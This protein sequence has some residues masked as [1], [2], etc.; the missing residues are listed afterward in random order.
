[1]EEVRDTRA[2]S[3]RPGGGAPRSTDGAILEALARIERRLD[4]VEALA[5]RARTD[6]THALAG[7]V[8]GFDGWMA[9][10]AERGVDV[11]E[12]AR[13]A[14]RLAERATDPRILG[15]LERLLDVVEQAPGGAAMLMDVVDGAVARMQAAGIDVDQRARSMLHAAERLTSPSTVAL[16]EATV[17]RAEALETLL[18]SSVL[19]PEA[20]RVVSAAGRAMAEAA[21]EVGP[22]IGLFGAMRALGDADVQTAA[23]FLVRFA[24]RLGGALSP[25]PRAPVLPASASSTSR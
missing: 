13:L 22:P 20:V 17:D 23:G 10:L 3:A 8:D 14:L 2:A 6:A 19:H 4:R 15:T 24:R 1:M 12:R 18:Q 7:A 16:L 25:D 21:S 5:E 9:T 11:D